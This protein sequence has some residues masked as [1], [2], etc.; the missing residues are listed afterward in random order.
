[1]K[2]NKRSMGMRKF[3]QGKRDNTF[4]HRKRAV[5]IRKAFGW[6]RTGFVS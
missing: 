3:W 2:I 6:S 4:A 1:M 5:G